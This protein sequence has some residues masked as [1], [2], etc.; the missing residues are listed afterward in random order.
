MPRQ[1]PYDTGKVKIGSRYE[2][3]RDYMTGEGYRI[4]RALLGRGRP[5]RRPLLNLVLMSLSVVIL[6]ATIAIL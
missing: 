2:P 4:Q 1:V 6:I 5:I 3:P